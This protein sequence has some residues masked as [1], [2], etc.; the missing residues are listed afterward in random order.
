MTGFDE[1]EGQLLDAIERRGSR[2]S[3]RAA[4]FVV[5]GSSA[6]VLALAGFAIVLLGH[7]KSP[8]PPPSRAPAAASPRDTAP[9]SL[10]GMEVLFKFPPGN[11]SEMRSAGAALFGVERRDRVCAP[12]QPPNPAGATISQGAPSAAL[13]SVLGV[14]R[15]PATRAD[16][17]PAPLY[18]TG[19]P[20]LF[21]EPNKAY[22][23][24]IRRA[25]VVNGVA[26]YLI[27]GVIG[28]PA[29]TEQVLNRCYAEEMQ[30]LRSRLAPATK[31]SRAATLAYGAR[32][33]A[34]NR[35]AVARQRSF[36]GVVE[37][38]WSLRGRGGGGGGGAAN[39]AAIEQQGMIGGGPGSALYGVVPSGVATV[40]LEWP[41]T[42]GAKPRTVTANVINNM[43][44]VNAPSQ[45]PA[46]FQPKMIWRAANGRVI[47]TVSG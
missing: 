47:K 36:D 16:R 12:V 37:L 34:D 13:L 28:T 22:V 27:P 41:A 4:T 5:V 46:T 20:L 43:F 38:D 45:D 19:R 14:L 33:F 24:Y 23:R 11:Q 39:A 6:V 44:V 29:P 2:R 25:R 10:G 7:G 31:S 3:P 8:S 32:V 21:G 30:A 42:A 17:L 9:Q 1:L 18:G 40:T 35:A 15:R 26:Y